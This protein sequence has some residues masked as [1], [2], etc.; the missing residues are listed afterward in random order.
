[1]SVTGHGRGL[2]AAVGLVIAAVVLTLLV[3]AQ[4]RSRAERVADALASAPAVPVAEIPAGTTARIHGRVRLGRQALV[5]PLSGRR[6]AHYELALEGPD[7]TVR[8]ADSRD[9]S[10]EDATGVARVVTRGATIAVTRAAH[11]VS[12][13][14][15][16]ARPGIDTGEILRSH[17]WTG[18]DPGQVRYRECALV[19]GARVAVAGT[20]AR[21][22]S[23]GRV[24]LRAAPGRQLHVG[25]AM[26]E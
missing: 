2:G 20:S 19:D 25:D 9:F 16:R 13:T 26:P 5:T 4:I 17:G 15:A 3:P 24:I 10:V 21:G 18:A 22:A 12:G 11:C 1:M 6:C 8:Q 14:L 23:R 7:R